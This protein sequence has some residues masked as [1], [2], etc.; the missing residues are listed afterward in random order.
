MDALRNISQQQF[1]LPRQGGG[2]RHLMPG[3]A[4][5]LLPEEVGLPHVQ[6]LLKSRLARLE[7]LGKSEAM[8]ESPADGGKRK[9]KAVAHEEE[10]ESVGRKAGGHAPRPHGANKVS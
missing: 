1:L 4:M 2:Y 7:K 10:S 8:S 9:D 6:N 5:T 3:R